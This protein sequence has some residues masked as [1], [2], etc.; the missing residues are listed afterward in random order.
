MNGTMTP[1]DTPT[2]TEPK[3][4]GMPRPSWPCPNCGRYVDERVKKCVCGMEF[5]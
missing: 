1:S 5:H 2:I 4:T 3:L